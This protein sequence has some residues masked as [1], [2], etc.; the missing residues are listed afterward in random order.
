MSR[1]T[2]PN[3]VFLF[4]DQQR[5]DTLGC[6]GQPLEVTPNLDEMAAEGVRFEHTFTC[7][8]VCGP[9]RACLQ[10]GKYATEV[11]VHTNHRMLPTGEETI[12]KILSRAGY[13]VGY[14][15]KWHLAS[16][17]PLGGPDDFRTRA[18]PIERRGGYDG[19]WMASDTL[20]HTS[21]SYD[22]HVFDAGGNRVEF[23][24]GRYRV[25]ALTDWALDFI[26]SKPGTR[27]GG[28]PFFLFVSYIEP[29]HQNDHGHYEGPVGSKER[30]GG[31]SPPGDLA[32]LGGDWRGE[33][34]DY[35]GCCSSLDASV[36]RVREKLGELGLADETVVFYTSDHGSH[37]R[38][39]NGEY[40]RSCHEGSIRVP[41]VVAGPGF[42]GGKVVGDLV[43]LID[44]PPTILR[45]AGLDPPTWMRGRPIQELLAGDRPPADWPD[46]V[47]LQISE[48]QCGRAIRTRRWKYSV[49]SP[50]RGGQDPDSTLYVEDFLYD[51][52]ADP[53][54]LDNLVG[55]PAH[56]STRRELAERLVSR[57]VAAG[58]AP[59]TI[60][61]ASRLP[62]PQ[63]LGFNGRLVRGE[64]GVVGLEVP[65]S[66]FGGG[67]SIVVGVGEVLEPLA[68][69]PVVVE[70]GGRWL[71]GT[72]EVSGERAALLTPGGEVVE[73]EGL[74]EDAVGRK[75]DATALLAGQADGGT[76]GG[77]PA[78]FKPEYHLLLDT[79]P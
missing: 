68:G 20:E 47:F 38:T 40:K 18:V 10:T 58:E 56:A 75:L 13:E 65:L 2:R 35:L 4:S 12:A 17:G 32:T 3:V 37:F 79:S 8:P 28:R 61:P 23:P 43:S 71:A 19:F 60:V 50:N 31:F 76:G 69:V 5:W 25:D 14:V 42:G 70:Y 30:F 15:G 66:P 16:C 48:S 59:P 51:L 62:E 55:S 29:H 46:D 39:R 63:V 73:F 9:A 7:Q 26:E 53:H 74:L 21:H 49:R 44:L 57:M 11:G 36:G 67:G 78:S 6:Y 41:L 24:Q 34:P 72:L 45:V 54:E 1:E 22:G 64:G 33:Y 52:E 27:Q 77:I